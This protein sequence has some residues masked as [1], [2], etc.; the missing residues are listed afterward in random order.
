[1]LKANILDVPEGV[2]EAEFW[3]KWAPTSEAFCRSR[4][5]WLPSFEGTSAWETFPMGK[6]AKPWKKENDAEKET[7]S[8]AVE[9]NAAH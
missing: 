4:D 9:D 5:E 2:D 1:M 3:R 6:D 8:M 7:N